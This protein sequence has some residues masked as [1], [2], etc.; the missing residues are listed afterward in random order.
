MGRRYTLLNCFVALN[1]IWGFITD[2]ARFGINYLAKFG[3]DSSKGLGASGEGR[4]SHLEVSKKL[5]MLGIGAAH[6]LDPNGIAWKQNKDFEN[7]LKRLNGDVVE[8]MVVEDSKK[9]DSGEEENLNGEGKKRKGKDDIEAQEKKKKKIDKGD[10][11]EEKEDSR[12]NE[13]VN[14]PSERETASPG[15]SEQRGRVRT[16]PRHRAYDLSLY[17]LSSSLNSIPQASC[18]GNRS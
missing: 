6:Q 9:A 2:A 8:G 16:L 13:S 7:L 15:P 4:K 1:F 14:P 10:G 11:D 18:T 5:D 12:A 17:Y 3:W